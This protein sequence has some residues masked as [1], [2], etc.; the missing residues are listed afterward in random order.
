MSFGLLTTSITRD[1]ESNNDRRKIYWAFPQG[2]AQLM[3]LL[4]LLPNA[5]ESDKTNF[6]W[7]E[8]RF[9]TQRSTT[10][11]SGTA[12]F[13]NA[14][15]SAF[16]DAAAFVAGTEYIVQVATTEQFKPTHVIEIRDFA[17]NSTTGD[18]VGVVTAIVSSTKLKFRPNAAWAAVENA[19]TKN[20][21][22]TVAII[23]TANR[24]NARSGAGH[25]FAP[26]NPYNYTQIFRGAFAIPRSTM[27]GGL[28]FQKNGPFDMMAKE[29]GLR[30][31]MEMEQAFTWGERIEQTVTDPETNDQT[32]E[33][34]TGG[35]LYFLKLWEAAASIYR[36]STSSAI[37]S[38]EDDD[39]RIV[40]VNGILTKE[41]Y[42]R[43]L[44]NLFRQ[45]NDVGY[46]KVC[47]CGAT[48]LS[49]INNL[50][51]RDRIVMS[52]I[53][54][55]KTKAKFIVYSHQ[56]LF[57]TVHYKTH[58]KFTEDPDKTDSGLFL[59]LGNL[60]YRPLCDSDTQFLNR[61]QENDRDGGKWE[62][63]SE[64]GLELKFPESCGYLKDVTRA[65]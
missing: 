54:E 41:R 16:S 36:G 50:F 59:D 26:V 19:T 40:S 44:Q 55:P 10:A 65:G 8:R 63:I 20:N 35:V 60:R 57:G 49:V 15:N 45:T 3:G 33:R 61:R 2:G 18:L 30:Y 27:K 32:Y 25:F 34:Q 14:D 31:M 23:G 51:D 6:G 58:P 53:E 39:K 13:T 46:E 38:N 62:W 12:P 9:P 1:Y 24:E 56:T 5:Q 64:C 48:F 28:V 4:A 52:S 7:F 29:N 43:W 47:L 17:Y 22:K 37:T 11:A 42:N 21:S